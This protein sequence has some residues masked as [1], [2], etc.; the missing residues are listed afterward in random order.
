MSEIVF[1]CKT[2]TPLFLF[3]ADGQT[4]ELRPPSIKGT[5]RFWW[6]T[7]YG[8]FKQN[9]LMEKEA[10]IFGGIGKGKGKSKFSVRVLSNIGSSSKPFNKEFLRVWSA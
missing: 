10:D 4:P 3:G 5:L 1:E 9:D 8:E 6:R 7:M 2:V